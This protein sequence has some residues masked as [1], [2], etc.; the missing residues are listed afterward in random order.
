[1]G[2]CVSSPH[3]QRKY[4][5]ADDLDEEIV[6]L[7]TFGTYRSGSNLV[8]DDIA[9]LP[10]THL[11]E[12][13]ISHSDELLYEAEIDHGYSFRG[14]RLSYLCLCTPWGLVYLLSKGLSKLLTIFPCDEAFCWVRKEYS[15]RTFFRIYPNRIGFNHPKVRF[16]WAYCGCGSWNADQILAHPFDRGAFGFSTVR[17]FAIDYFCCTWPLYGSS[18]ARHRCACNGPIW[19]RMLTDCGGCW[20]DEWI[21]QV[22]FCSYR[23][24]GLAQP[25]EVAFAAS[26]ALQAYFEGRPL[27]RVDMDKCLDLWRNLISEEHD[28]VRRKRPVC[29]E[30]YIVPIVD[31]R[32]CYAVSHLKRRIPFPEGQVTDELKEIYGRYDEDCRNQIERYRKFTGPVRA[33]TLCRIAGCRRFCGR[34]GFLFCTEGC[35]HCNRKAGEPAPPFE[36]HDFD[37]DFDASTVLMKVLGPPPPNVLIK[38]WRWDPEKNENV[39]ETIPEQSEKSKQ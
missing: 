28:P 19:N 31:C 22:F 36:C 39:L 38:R 18:V 23:Y 29:C 12:H 15:T 3:G 16:P 7:R 21:C 33:S 4:R 20:C 14:L 34:K 17:C 5:D 26:I 30:P 1:M 37:D 10:S 6:P 24:T 11:E 27:T 8:P 25:D 35:H 2:C 9:G 13:L 32:R